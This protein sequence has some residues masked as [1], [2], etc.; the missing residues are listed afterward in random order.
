MSN[1]P[2]RLGAVRA[3]FG[4]ELRH[5]QVRR[6]LRRIRVYRRI[7]Q[8]VAQSS[9]GEDRKH[10]REVHRLARELEA[11]LAGG[12]SPVRRAELSQACR[13]AG[14]EP[15]QMRTSLIRLAAFADRHAD[16]MPSQ[17]RPSPPA[18]LVQAIVDVAGGRLGKPTKWPE[19][20]FRQACV[21]VFTLADIASS[22]DRAIDAVRESQNASPSKTAI[23][24]P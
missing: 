5:D 16:D 13:S 17:R 10:L 20:P 2:D 9:I 1:R 8:D 12:G 7:Q 14:I 24:R 6:L 11:A 22:P 15:R 18:L 4:L 21:A 3:L 23:T 19:S